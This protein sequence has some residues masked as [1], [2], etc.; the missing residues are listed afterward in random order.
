MFNVVA[1]IG[2]G[3]RRDQRG[4]PAAEKEEQEAAGDDD[5]ATHRGLLDYPLLT[6]SF[7]HHLTSI[8]VLIYRH[9]I[10]ITV[11][12][13]GANKNKRKS[14]IGRFSILTSCFFD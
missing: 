6:S 12:H 14:F 3:R 7:S 9:F 5:A 10:I 2:G 11:D 4:E 8:S 13:L 1:D